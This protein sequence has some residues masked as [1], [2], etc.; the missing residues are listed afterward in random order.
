M[1]HE[2]ELETSEESNS[3]YGKLVKSA[4][5]YSAEHYDDVAKTLSQADRAVRAFVKERPFAAVGLALALG[6]FVAR[7]INGIR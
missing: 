4:M 1:N 6:Y 5:D 2:R 7:S 3:Q